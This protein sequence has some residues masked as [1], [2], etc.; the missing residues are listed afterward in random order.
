MCVDTVMYYRMLKTALPEEESAEA[1]EPL[2]ESSIGRNSEQ[3]PMQRF[4]S[5]NNQLRSTITV[6]LT[7]PV[8]ETDIQ[9]TSTTPITFAGG[10]CIPLCLATLPIC[11]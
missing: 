11:V 2:L 1:I 4:L 7:I 10:S 6:N 9:V 5:L 8:Y 3:G